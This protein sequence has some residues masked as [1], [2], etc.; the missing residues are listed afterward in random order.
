M[1]SIVSGADRRY[2]GMQSKGLP[3]PHDTQ[4]KPAMH[5]TTVSTVFATWADDG[6]L[7]QA[8]VASVR[9]LATERPLDTSVLQ[10]DGTNTVAQQGAMALA[11]QATSTRKGRRASPCPT[12]MATCWLPCPWHPSMRR[13]WFC[14]PRGC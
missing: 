13:T 14:C 11:T 9:H 2:T 4:G 5:S 6:S 12:T 7:W 3:M 8:C 10:G 1:S